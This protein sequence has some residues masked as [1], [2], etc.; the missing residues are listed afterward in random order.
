MRGMVERRIYKRVRVRRWIELGAAPA[1]HQ[2]AG[3]VK[4]HDE[5]GL[6][7]SLAVRK[8]V[9]VDQE[10][11][12]CHGPCGGEKNQDPRKLFVQVDFPPFGDV[13]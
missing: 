5:I 9:I 4:G 12:R 3:N 6:L 13:K 10:Y 7:E 2:P 1:Q 8:E 11:P